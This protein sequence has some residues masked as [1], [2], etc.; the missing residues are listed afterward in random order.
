M[1]MA[2]NWLIYLS[3][4]FPVGGLLGKIRGCGLVGEGVVSEVGL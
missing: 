2:P 4:W 1:R 3:F